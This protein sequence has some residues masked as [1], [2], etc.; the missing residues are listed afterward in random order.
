MA[1]SPY[2]VVAD[3]ASDLD[4]ALPRIAGN[5]DYLALKPGV[6]FVDPEGMKRVKPWTVA[7][8]ADYL[9]VPEGQQF[10]DPEGQLRMKPKYEGVGF[11]AQTLYDMARTPAEQ[12]KALAH[13][14]GDERVKERPDTGGLYVDMGDGRFLAPGA[15]SF[16]ERA[17]ATVVSEAAPVLG[18]VVGGAGGA[19][20]GTALGPAGTVGGALT[21]A[22]LGGATGQAFNDSILQLAGIYD[23][24]ASEQVGNLA[25]AAAWGAAGEG[26]GR[27]LA[28]AAPTVANALNTAGEVGSRY[29]PRAL[30]WLTGADKVP[31]A[32]LRAGRLAEQGVRIPPSVWM[33]EAPY[34]KKSVEEFDPVFRS[35]N[36]IRQS[37]ETYREREANAILDQLGIPQEARAPIRSKSAAEYH[38]EDVA[39]VLQKE[40]LVDEQQ[41]ARRL[42]ERGISREEALKTAR[43]MMETQQATDMVVSSKDAGAALLA[44]TG[45]EMAE[46]DARLEAAELQAKAQARAFAGESA[47][48]QMKALEVLEVEQAS[49]REAAQKVVDAGWTA[50]GDTMEKSLKFDRPGDLVRQA[51]DKVRTLRAAIGQRASKLYQAADSAAGDAMPNLDAVGMRQTA[52]DMLESLPEQFASKHPDIVKGIRDLESGQTTFG[53][54]RR[55]RSMLRHDVDYLDL[56]PSQREGVFRLF[57]TKVDQVIHDANAVSELL[58]AAKML[59]QA[60]AFYAKNIPRFKDEKVR[61]IVRE[62]EAGMPAD[63]QVLARELLTPGHTER[64]EKVRKIV[65]KNLWASVQ[66]ADTKAMV[67]AS[68]TIVP[69]EID[70]KEFAS[71]VAERSRNGILRSAYGREQADALERQARNALQVEGKIRIDADE[72]D[73]VSTLMRKIERAQAEAETVGRLDPLGALERDIQRIEQQTQAQK[74]LMREDLRDDPLRFLYEASTGA[75]TAADR[76]LGSPDLLIATARKFGSDSPEFSLLRQVGAL[77]I[78]QHPERALKEMPETL[79]L[80]FPGGAAKDVVELAKNMEFLISG[81]PDVGG[82]IAAQSRV[83]NPWSHIAGAWTKHIPAIMKPDF[84]GRGLLS[85]W[86]QT[87]ARTSEPWFV[88]YVARGLRGDQEARTAA[89]IAFNTKLD[90]YL[91][92]LG[93]GAGQGLNELTAPPGAPQTIREP[94]KPALERYQ[95]QSR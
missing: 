28:R 53:Q 83:L 20:G 35:Q 36:E 42:E 59:D 66:A 18:T 51:A 23:R 19:V 40:G 43:A 16:P 50:I 88:K 80:I 85:F 13:E 89:K 64:I 65:G 56:T 29:L 21:G 87:M 44:K 74:K 61:W 60:D 91:G 48:T 5:D 9:K 71:Q 45:R 4:N 54:L 69:G 67:D 6:E 62:L 94:R 8:D 75:I 39:A 17:A 1:E 38:A 95:G 84:I 73:T 70:A 47:K 81:R 27:T 79:D 24:S 68:R 32:T 63:P 93:A 55:L 72:R 46:A 15:G 90:E 77:R 78:L 26:V 22:A 12:R 25:S 14:Y 30:A 57:A 31:E 10:V 58:A 82:F 7:N 3:D 86:Y 11:T 34:L 52:K 49:N 76:I 92:A 33:K 37:A 41:I 2:P